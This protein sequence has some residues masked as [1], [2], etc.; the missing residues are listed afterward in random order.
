MSISS[1]TFLINIS[2]YQRPQTFSIIILSCNEYEE[3]EDDNA[4]NIII[5]SDEME[6]GNENNDEDDDDLNEAILNSPSPPSPKR[7]RLL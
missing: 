3:S 6:E 4:D 1:F 7:P 5:S 2:Q